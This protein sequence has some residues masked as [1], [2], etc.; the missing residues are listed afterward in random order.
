M[1]VHQTKDGRWY[2]NYYIHDPESKKKKAKKEYFGRGKEA[3]ASACNRDGELKAQGQ[4]NQYTGTPRPTSTTIAEIAAEYIDSKNDMSEASMY[5]LLTKLTGILL[6]EL[7]H[8][9]VNRLTPHRLDLYVK[10]RLKAPVVKR[11]GKK[12]AQKQIPVKNENGSVRTIS[13]TTVHRELTDL[14]AIINWAVKRRIITYNPVAGYE[15]P[16]RDD[17]IIRPPSTSEIKEILKEASP[18]LFRALIINY[19]SGLRPGEAEL[20]YLSW[21]DIDWDS[22]SILIR[23]AKKGGALQRTIA[24]HVELRSY[25]EIWKKEDVKNQHDYI[26]YWKDQPVKSFKKAFAAAKRRAGITRRLRPY[27][28]RHKAVTSMLENGGDLKSVSMIAGH[29]DTHI[30]TKVYQ[31]LSQKLVRETINK[32]PSLGLGNDDGE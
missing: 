7:G 16:K 26:I 15:K 21:D 20:A 17:A 31:H 9:E 32:I 5:N 8:I 25:F 22:Q 14:Q 27:D 28:F 10:K 1:S 18:H 4:I 6:P 19:Y 29:A 12:G 30:T 23:S 2:V 11:I 24:I 13:K 3:E